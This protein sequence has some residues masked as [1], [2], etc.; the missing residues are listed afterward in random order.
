MSIGKIIDI[1]GVDGTGKET[2]SQLLYERLKK[3]GHAVKLVS[4]PN[5]N[6]LSSSLVKMYLNGEFGDDPEDCNVYA[7][8]AFFA[9][10]RF[11][12]YAKELKNFYENGGI[13]IMDR[14]TTSNMIHQASKIKDLK[15]KDEYLNW[16]WNLEFNLFKLPVPDIV[17]LLDV[18]PEIS[19][20]LMRNRLNKIDN[21]KEKDIHEKHPEYLKE[22]YE[23]AMYV[24]EKYDWDTIDCNDGSNIKSIE[25]IES[26]IYQK[27]KKCVVESNSREG[28]IK[29]EL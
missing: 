21:K 20:N 16:L 9:V 22:S 28:M 25:E 1:E 26:L 10:D 19:Q 12:T 14:Y 3:E 15:E 4:F 23:N 5:Y 2:Q 18:K 8:S 13:I 29:N 7:V 11:A 6:S 24:A 17:I 27:I